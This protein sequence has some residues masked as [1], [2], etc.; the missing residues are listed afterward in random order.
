MK[1]IASNPGTNHRKKNTNKVL[2]IYHRGTYE[3]RKRLTAYRQL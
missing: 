1:V 3:K 2:F